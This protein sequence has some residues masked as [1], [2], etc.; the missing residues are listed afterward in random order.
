MIN[1]AFHRRGE[2]PVI[3]RRDEDVPLVLPDCVG[4]GVDCCVVVR[5]LGQWERLVRWDGGALQGEGEQVVGE[6]ED[7]E[8]CVWRVWEEGVDD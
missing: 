6:V 5:V 2:G 4:P 1:S 7:G 3:L 8:C